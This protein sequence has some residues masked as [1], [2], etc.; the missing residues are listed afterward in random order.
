MAL[1]DDLGNRMK[2]NYE[3]RSKTYLTR[4]VPVIMRLD[5]R[6]FHS[7]TKQMRKPFDDILVKTMQDT[8]LDLCKNVQGCVLGYTQ[9]DEITLVLVD[10]KTLE[11]EAWFDYQVQ[12]IVS[13]GASIATLSFNKHFAENVAEMTGNTDEFKAYAKKLGQAMFDARAFNI[14]KEEVCNCVLWRQMDAERNSV[15]MVAQANFSHKELQ[16]KSCN[17]LQDMLM[18]QK[19]INWNNFPTYLKRGSCAVRNN[20]GWFVDLD[21]PKFVNEGR[22]YIEKRINF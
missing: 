4:R 7:F 18:L 8:M 11:S 5:G 19:G 12:K 14:P 3:N 17:E 2:E 20:D 16:G 1:R 22:D 15:Q 21:I 6:A 10:Y 9:S 13:I